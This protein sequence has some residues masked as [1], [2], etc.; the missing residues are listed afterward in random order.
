M[1][2][3]KRTTITINSDEER[4]GYSVEGLDTRIFR[5]LTSHLSQRLG[6]ESL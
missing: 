2:K 4:K 5:G 3:F 1:L 6:M